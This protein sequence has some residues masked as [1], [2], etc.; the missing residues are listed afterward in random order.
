MQ[1]ITTVAGLKSAII[2]LE[3]EQYEKGRQLK[4]QVYITLDSLRPVNL[5]RS[6]LRDIFSS[7][8]LIGNISGTTLGL[9]GGFLLKKLFVGRSGNLFKK[10]L[11]SLLQFGLT[12]MISK[13]SDFLKSVGQVVWNHLFQRKGN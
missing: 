3:A 7:G 9:A 4:K 5:I 12:N 6:S 1:K 11:G 13:N 8:D 2:S 10:L